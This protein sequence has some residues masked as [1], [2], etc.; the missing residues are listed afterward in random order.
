MAKYRVTFYTSCVIIF[1]I[2]V[3]CENAFP[4]DITKKALDLSL[5]FKN[6]LLF[7]INTDF[8]GTLKNV[9]TVQFSN[10]ILENKVN[11]LLD[12]NLIDKLDNITVKDSNSDSQNKIDNTLDYISAYGDKIAFILSIKPNYTIWWLWQHSMFANS[13]N[14]VLQTKRVSDY[15]INMGSDD[16]KMKFVKV[17]RAIITIIKQLENFI[18]KYN[19]TFKLPE[20]YNDLSADEILRKIPEALNE[21]DNLIS[22]HYKR[23]CRNKSEITI[24]H[25]KPINLYLYHNVKSA[26]AVELLMSKKVYIKWSSFWE[27]VVE[28]HKE[29]VTEWMSESYYNMRT[30]Y[31][32]IF[33]LLKASVYGHL[34]IH[35]VLCKRI[36]KLSNIQNKINPPKSKLSSLTPYWKSLSTSLLSFI[37]NFDLIKD[38]KISKLPLLFKGSNYELKVIEQLIEEE[39]IYIENFAFIKEDKKLL[40]N[41]ISGLKTVDELISA[42]KLNKN[43]LKKYL[44]VVFTTFKNTNF[45]TA[46]MFFECIPK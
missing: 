24:S 27:N 46:N 31:D 29:A 33:V 34:R 45:S 2:Y 43:D 4:P 37:T 15:V 36:L 26:T 16:K 6:V 8:G 25:Y 12:Y 38:E 14:N 23:A 22:K 19:P 21:F 32:S 13:I 1:S 11:I 35:I 39:F 41:F 44:N 17:N 30:Y 7:F 18:R 20:N 9:E 10:R 3:N 5:M 42:I 40:F 28:N